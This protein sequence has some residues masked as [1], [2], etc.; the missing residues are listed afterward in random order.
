MEEKELLKKL[1]LTKGTS[2]DVL[3]K[4]TKLDRDSLS[5]LLKQLEMKLKV[6]RRKNGDYVKTEDATHFTGVLEM[7]ENGYGFLV[8]E[9]GDNIFI[10]K[11]NLNGAMHKD[12][13]LIDTYI[14]ADKRVYGNVLKVY[15]KKHRHVGVVYEEDGKY[16]ARLDN[17]RFCFPVKLNYLSGA[18]LD[19]KVVVELTSGLE[20]DC[21]QGNVI[22]V[23]GHKLDPR[24]DVLSIMRE[25]EIPSRFPKDV[26]AEV[27]KIP[28]VVTKEELE[29]RLDLRE[30][31][32]F[33]IDGDTA[34]D[35]DD[36]V[37]I[38]KLANGNYKLG[39]HIADVSH[40][41]KEGSILDQEAYIR[42]VSVYT[43]G[44]VTPMLPH[45]LSN[46]ICS[47]NPA[48]DRLTLSCIMEISSDG[49]V[50]HYEIV[51]SVIHSKKRMTYQKV[52]QVLEG[53]IPSDYLE[54][55]ED[56]KLMFEL[57]KILRK[58]R[59]KEGSINFDVGEMVID[60][61]EFGIPMNITKYERGEGEKIIE[62]FMIVANETVAGYAYYLQSPFIYRVHKVP[63]QDKLVE[64]VNDAEKLGIEIE[65]P[66]NQKM[67]TP[68]TLQMQLEKYKEHPNYPILSNLLLRSMKKAEYLTSN[69]ITL[70]CL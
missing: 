57:S 31:T 39:V 53:N 42:G 43:P 65:L 26:V 3:R 18:F 14:L 66:I 20:R 10:P 23:I 60:T 45:K 63:S 4:K 29:N 62:D 2:L 7:T 38:G 69:H 67:I 70:V 49:T 37:S 36:A 9:E 28:T 41:V 1:D 30:E 51:P 35:F 32:I 44:Y 34:K 48:V 56:L 19:N 25:L 47:L 13:I 12:R 68:K 54:Y 16:Y 15:A 33:T 27:E 40:Y 17:R 11:K 8:N 59:E 21:Y 61:N 22:E 64:F 6:I 55:Q 50:I 58:K 5:E 46:G 52:N 24:V